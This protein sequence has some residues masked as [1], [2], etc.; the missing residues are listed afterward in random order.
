MNLRYVHTLKHSG[1]SFLVI[2]TRKLVKFSG[3][4]YLSSYHSLVD[5]TR[6][7]VILEKE[8]LVKVT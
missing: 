4:L 5:V 2:I 3:Y 8:V 6:N 7:L 1:Q